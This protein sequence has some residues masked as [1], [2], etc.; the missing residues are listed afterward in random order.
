VLPSSADPTGCA[1]ADLVDRVREAGITGM[2]GAGFPTYRKLEEARH[3]VVETLVINAAECEPGVRADTSLL[4]A[5]ADSV[6]RGACAVAAIVGARRCLVGIEPRNADAIAALQAALAAHG[7]QEV[8]WR[9]Y[10]LPERYPV[11]SERSLIRALTGI[12]LGRGERPSAQ[13]LIC[14]N[15]ATLHALARALHFGEPLTRRVLSVGGEGALEPGEHWAFIGQPIHEFRADPQFQTLHGGPLAGWPVRGEAAVA[16]TTFSL[17][18]RQFT[19]LTEDPCIRCQRCAEVCPEP[20]YPE[21]LLRHSRARNVDGLQRDGLD[22]CVECGACD[23]VCP[24][25]IPLLATFREAKSNL[26]GATRSA[27]RAVDARVRSQRHETRESAQRRATDAAR[28]ARLDRRR[29]THDS[30]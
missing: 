5:D 2:G 3:G 20:L 10:G 13:G 29:A 19:P 21:R 11:G 4:I 16:K 6:V 26:A 27:A 30:S 14:F 22:L 28:Q 9:C 18:F 8:R 17:H 1:P 15:V 24:S 12:Q 25:R 23:T 7:G